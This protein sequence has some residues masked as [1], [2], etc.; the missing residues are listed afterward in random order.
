MS[1]FA[2]AYAGVH[3]RHGD[4]P[5]GIYCRASL[6]PFLDAEPM[7]AVTKAGIDF[8]QDLFAQPYPF[9]KYDQIFVPEFN[10][11][12]MENVAAIGYTDTVIFRDPPTEDQLTRRARVP[13]PRT[14]PHVVRRPGDHA[15]VE[16]P[17]AQ[18][19]VRLLR[20]LPGPRPHRRASRRSGWTS[21]PA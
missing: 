8:Y 4:I 21:T 1:V 5:L 19:V 17:V 20:R 13:D 6:L 2:G 15:L 10:W 12:G 18:R 9:G 16:R 7:F 14:G 11:G 3:D